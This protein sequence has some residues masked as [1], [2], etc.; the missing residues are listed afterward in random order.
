[1]TLIV[2]ILGGAGVQDLDPTQK[3][4]GII[5]GAGAIQVVTSFA[6]H[7]QSI[8]CY[9]LVSKRIVGLERLIGVPNSLAAQTHRLDSVRG[10]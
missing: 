10:A 4:H 2:L 6:F 3:P 9:R 8:L 5:G 7:V 1:M